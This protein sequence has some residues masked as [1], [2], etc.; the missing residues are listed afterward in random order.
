VSSDGGAYDLWL[1]G[2][3]GF[4]RHFTGHLAPRRER[5]PKPEVRIDYEP[6]RQGLT[7]TLLN[8]GDSPCTFHLVAN[9]YHEHWEP[10][11]LRVGPRDDRD[12]FIALSRSANWYDFTVRVADDAPYSRRFAGRV[13]TGRHSLSD[14]GLGGRA[15]GQQS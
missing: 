1:L 13:E 5:A 7:L 4:H 3:N 14:P 12:L 2:P 15:R 11:N 10:L 6:H 9:A 8:R